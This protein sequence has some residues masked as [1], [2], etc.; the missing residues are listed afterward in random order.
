VCRLFGAQVPLNAMLLSALGFV[1]SWPVA[2]AVRPLFE[3]RGA[4]DPVHALKSGF[5]IPLLV[6]SLGAMLLPLPESQS[7]GTSQR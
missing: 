6:L 4:P 1:A 7:G 3:T 2:V 5:V